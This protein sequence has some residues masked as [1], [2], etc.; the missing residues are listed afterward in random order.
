MSRVFFLLALVWTT[1]IS[2]DDIERFR[3]G[4]KGCETKFSFLQNACLDTWRKK[5]ELEILISEHSWKSQEHSWKSQEHEWKSQEHAWK[6]HDRDNVIEFPGMSV[7]TSSP[8][9]VT[10]ALISLVLF[11]AASVLQCCAIDAPWPFPI[12]SIFLVFSIGLDFLFWLAYPSQMMSCIFI[13]IFAT[14]T[15][16]ALSVHFFHAGRIHLATVWDWNPPRLPPPPP[17]SPLPLPLPRTPPRSTTAAR[18]RHARLP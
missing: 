4:I 11:L 14:V 1:D 16:C 17:P 9:S 6:S 3:N 15:A 18:P 12:L 8:I 10:I 7:D 13:A 2:C 5:L